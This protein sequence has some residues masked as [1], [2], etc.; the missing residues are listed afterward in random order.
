MISANQMSATVNGFNPGTDDFF[1]MTENFTISVS[2]TNIGGYFVVGNTITI[3][4]LDDGQSPGEN[5]H[6]LGDG[7][8]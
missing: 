4:I 1:E 6:V 3:D 2:A 8:N 5:P 7:K